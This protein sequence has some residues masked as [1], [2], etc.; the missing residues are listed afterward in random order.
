MERASQFLRSGDE[1]MIYE[2]RKNAE[3]TV[4]YWDR[5]AKKYIEEIYHLKEIIRII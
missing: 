1:R 2:A 3:K 5:P 4:Y